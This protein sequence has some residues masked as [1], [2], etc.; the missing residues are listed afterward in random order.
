MQLTDSWTSRPADRKHYMLQGNSCA[1]GGIGGA[2][3]K[4]QPDRA[5][6]WAESNRNIVIAPSQLAFFTK[7]HVQDLNSSLGGNPCLKYRHTSPGKPQPALVFG[8]R[9]GGGEGE[10]ELPTAFPRDFLRTNNCFCKQKK[11]P[12]ISIYR[13]RQ[14]PGRHLIS[15]DPSPHSQTVRRVLA[16]GGLNSAHRSSFYF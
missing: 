15:T 13:R 2:S 11:V 10:G 3:P 1:R 16:T 12:T 14:L 8:G 4:R 9:G 5:I 7:L 6:H